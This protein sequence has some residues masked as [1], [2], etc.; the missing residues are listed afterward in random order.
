MM[1]P[2]DMNKATIGQ[3]GNRDI[4]GS[5]C[6]IRVYTFKRFGVEGSRQRCN[7]PHWRDRQIYLKREYLVGMIN[8]LA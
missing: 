2:R 6:G 8:P 5:N 3:S 4:S 7:T 1:T